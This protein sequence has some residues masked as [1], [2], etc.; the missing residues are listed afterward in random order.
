MKIIEHKNFRLCVEPWLIGKYDAKY[1][2]RKCKEIQS[3]IK[4]HV[5]DIG[6]MWIEHDTEITCSHCGLNWEVDETGEP[7]CC[8]EAIKEFKLQKA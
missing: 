2:E 7:V 6:Q 4:R 8:N 3:E 1:A 5:D